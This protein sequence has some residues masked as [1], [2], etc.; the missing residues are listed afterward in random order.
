MELEKKAQDF[1]KANDLT[2]C[3]VTSD[4]Q[5]FLLGAERFAQNHARKVGGKVETI[6]AAKIEEKKSTSVRYKG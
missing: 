3:L 1:L 6:K 4:G 2:E 5:I